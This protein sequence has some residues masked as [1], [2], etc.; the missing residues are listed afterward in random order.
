VAGLGGHGM[1]TSAGAG[2]A[3]ASLLLDEPA[4]T[5]IEPTLAAALAPQGGRTDR[6]D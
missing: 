2:R 1:S 6:R 4:G 5:R 3:A